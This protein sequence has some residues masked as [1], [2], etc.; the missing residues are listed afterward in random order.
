MQILLNLYDSVFWHV[1]D[2]TLLILICS[3]QKIIRSN[4]FIRFTCQSIEHSYINFANTITETNRRWHMLNNTWTKWT[5]DSY[6]YWQNIF[7]IHNSHQVPY[8]ETKERVK[9]K[10]T[11]KYKRFA[12]VLLLL[13]LS[14]LHSS[15]YIYSMWNERKFRNSKRR[16]WYP[17][18]LF[19]YSN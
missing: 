2:K 4:V 3:N 17:H 9:S 14:I 1:F 15:W 11:S 5:N 8:T 19:L 12:Y 10:S 18:F 7:G 6:Y 16:K 13:N